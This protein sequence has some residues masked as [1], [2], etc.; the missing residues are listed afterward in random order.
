MPACHIWDLRWN[1]WFRDQ[2][3]RFESLETTIKFW[4]K[5]RNLKC[6]LVFANIYMKRPFAA[7][8]MTTSI[9][10]SKLLSLSGLLCAPLL[11]VLLV[12]YR[13]YVS[14]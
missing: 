5:F 12:C 3:I 8:Y 1:K 4:N 6:N 2:N 13:T 11:P 9:I 10:V 7:K 14:I